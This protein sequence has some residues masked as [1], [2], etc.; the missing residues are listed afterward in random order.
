MCTKNCNW[1]KKK[2]RRDR[3]GWKFNLLFAELFEW[4]CAVSSTHRYDRVSDLLSGRQ[5]THAAQR[6]A[7][8]TLTYEL[9]T[10]EVLSSLSLFAS[11]YRHR[12]GGRVN[13][14]YT[15]SA[16]WLSA[17][18]SLS[19]NTGSRVN[20]LL[21]YRTSHPWPSSFSIVTS[22]SCASLMLFPAMPQTRMRISISQ[23]FAERFHKHVGRHKSD[24]ILEFHGFVIHVGKYDSSMHVLRDIH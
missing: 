4:I 5:T 10:G 1:F 8:S 19:F 3:E 6:T 18:F 16:P 21:F 15:A 14:P 13:G 23:D 2:I 12:D 24:W 11:I 22:P 20:R 7:K 17:T 9:G